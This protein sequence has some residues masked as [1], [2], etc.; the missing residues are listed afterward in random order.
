MFFSQITS[1]FNVAASLVLQEYIGALGLVVANCFAM[2][3]RISYTLCYIRFARFSWS[4][5]AFL[6]AL[7]PRKRLLLLM[8]GTCALTIVTSN[9][10]TAVHVFG[11]VF[12]LI[13]T[14]TALLKLERSSLM[15]IRRSSKKEA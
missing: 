8:C 5:E 3:I 10:H 13:I 1:V 14:L 15:T 12:T 4:S 9:I 7:M 2:S 11:G 6:P